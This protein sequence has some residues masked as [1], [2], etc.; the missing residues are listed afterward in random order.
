MEHCS[1]LVIAKNA[2][3]VHYR[4]QQLT[5]RWGSCTASGEILLNVDLVKAPK[6]SIDYVIV[7]ELCHLKERRHGNKFAAL[8]DK[9]LP[10]WR[11]RREKL[12]RLVDT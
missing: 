6:E 5:K 2:A 3:P 1:A 10:D 8:M 4:L 7:H 12:N 11:T 9:A